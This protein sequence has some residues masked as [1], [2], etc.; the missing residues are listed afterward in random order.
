M[1]KN[2]KRK[3]P[4]IALAL[5]IVI[6]TFYYCF[7]TQGIWHLQNKQQEILALELEMKGIMQ[8][9]STLEQQINQWNTCS[10]YKEKTAREQ[11]QLA[12]PHEKVYFLS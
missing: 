7:G 10:F 11:L 1:K 4:L 12:H 6:F 5:E 8:E 9:V 3:V 2:I